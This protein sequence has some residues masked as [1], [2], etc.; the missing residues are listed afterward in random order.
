MLF[1]L[2]TIFIGII[3]DDH[4]QFNMENAY[5]PAIMISNV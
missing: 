5:N 4:T 1:C 3:F 2:S